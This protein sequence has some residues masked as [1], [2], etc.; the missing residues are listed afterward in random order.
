MAINLEIYDNMALDD[1]RRFYPSHI[2]I[3]PMEPLKIHFSLLESPEE[4]RKGIVS[5]VTFNPGDFIAQLTGTS[6]IFQT[7]YTLQREE[8]FYLHDP[9]FGGFISHNCDPVA[10]LR[11]SDFTLHALKK[12]IP[13]TPLNINYN[14]TEKYLYQ[15][16]LCACNSMDKEGNSLCQGWI[17]G[18]GEKEESKQ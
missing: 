10:Y 18:Y 5:L 12:I 4:I 8:G 2:P 9:F 13:F 16:F 15:E 1:E 7:L 3:Q 17:S 11:M 14:S 6:L